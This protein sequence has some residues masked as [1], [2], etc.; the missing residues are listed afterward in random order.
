MKKL[1][2]LAIVGR[3]NVGKSAL[4][5]RLCKKKIA[6]VDEMEGTTRDRLYAEADFFG[7]PF[8]VIDTGGMD[9]A[10]SGPFNKEILQQAEIAIEEADAMILVVDAISGVTHLDEQVARILHRSKKPITLA[11]NKVDDH[12][13]MPLLHQFH[14]LGFSSMVPISASQGYQIAELLEIALKG[15]EE[16]V[17]EEESDRIHVAILGR[18]NVGKS[19]L[20]NFLLQEQR[21]VVSPIPGT[22]RDSVDVDIE[23]NGIGFRLIDTA[24]IRRKKSEHEV[25]DKFA[26]IRTERALE[27][28][29][30]CIL[31]L[32]AEEG[33]TAQEK[34]IAK[35]IEAMGKGCILLVN[36]WDLMSDVRMEHYL[37]AIHDA[38][39]F[40]SYCPT[41]FTSSKTGRN[42]EKIYELV[43]QV[44]LESS[45][46]IT[47]GQLNKFLEQTIQKY[48]P[49]MLN[50][51]KRLRI[52]YI[53]QIQTNPPHFVLFV[54]KTDLML[55]SYKKYLINQF[56]ESYGFTGVPIIFTLKGKKE[57]EER[58]TSGAEIEEI[59][60]AE[61]F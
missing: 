47:T 2:K 31:M 3:P 34:R 41:L 52:Y 48:H 49:P 24:G 20:V 40:L 13:Q 33:I 54:N 19:T 53:A 12:S 9:A 55:E 50:G 42:L 14:S 57:R 37:K 8:L 59:C 60:E 16:F 17:P 61:I 51:G 32:S 21:C 18:P 22:T 29:H 23:V 25:V 5:N 36:K 45:R 11:V 28:A 39:P 56:R 10:S 6:I 7:T 30:V 35:E 15:I 38:A 46:R 44:H 1:F 27:R 4:F 43:Q 58:D 26:A